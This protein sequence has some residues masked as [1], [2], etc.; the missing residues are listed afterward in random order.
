MEFM[1]FIEVMMN[2]PGQQERQLTN[3]NENAR[4]IIAILGGRCEN[5]YTLEKIC[6][7]RVVMILRSG[8]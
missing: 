2:M 1:G 6:G 5:Y 4:K 8:C 7:M 3:L